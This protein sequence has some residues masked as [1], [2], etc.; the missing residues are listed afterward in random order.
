MSSKTEDIVIQN[1]SNHSDQDGDEEEE[2]KIDESVLNGYMTDDNQI[3]PDIMQGVRSTDPNVRLEAVTKLRQ[4]ASHRESIVVQPILDSDL[5]P[6]IIELICSDDPELQMQV[7]RIVAVITGSGDSDQVSAPVEAGA[8]PKL[9][10]VA[11]STKSDDLRD[12]VFLVL[13]NIGGDSHE[14]GTKLVDEGG[15]K[16]ML[17]ILDDIS[18]NA[19]SHRYQAACALSSYA[20]TNEKKIPENEVDEATV[21]KAREQNLIPRLVRLCTSQDDD[22]RN[23]AHQCV[24]QII[25]YSVDGVGDLI[26]AG[27]LDVLKAHMASESG[28]ERKNACFAASNLVVD[29]LEYA[30]ALIESGLVL[31]LVKILSDQGD[32]SGARNDAAWTL[33][34]LATNWGQNHHEILNM[35]LEV[36]ALEA[37]CSGLSSVHS[38]AIE[39]LLKG[40]LVL[41]KTQWE[42]RQRA[43]ER[44]KAGDGIERLRT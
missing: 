41:V 24:R 16:P 14:L 23:Q 13:G 22:T 39:V 3:A 44:V 27:I 26:S 25:L 7:I 5:L 32:K 4:L 11:S 34:S 21:E 30:K 18:P 31:P 38:S 28:P 20:H 15:L 1:A 40:I 17:D 6:T 42:G 19:T 10:S 43:V 37:F 9:I 8:L 33:S 12:Y 35:L 36:N 2:E 29:K